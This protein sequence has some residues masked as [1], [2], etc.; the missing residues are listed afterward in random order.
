MDPN[1]EMEVGYHGGTATFTQRL[2]VPETA[3]PGASVPVKTT[4]RFMACTDKSCLPPKNVDLTGLAL[5]IEAGS[6]RAEYSARQPSPP[7]RTHQRPSGAATSAAT[8]GA[9]SNQQGSIWPFLL[10][11]FGA[12]LIALVTPCVFP[13]IPVTLAFFTKQA[14][15]GGEADARAAQRAV[16]R[17]AAVYSLGIVVSFT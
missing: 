6:P 11:A 4:V 14:T 8:S 15:A 1:F 9:T 12:G 5:A 7:P 13:M 2:Q 17:L 16:V 3:Q 10:A